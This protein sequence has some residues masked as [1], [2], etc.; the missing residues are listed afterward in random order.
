[1]R[2]MKQQF[3]T[4]EPSQHLTEDKESQENP[5]VEMADLR[6]HWIHPDF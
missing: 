2:S 4:W 3:G 1:M 6:S 5:R